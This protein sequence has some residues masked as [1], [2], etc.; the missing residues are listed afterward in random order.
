MTSI[1]SII[2]QLPNL[3]SLNLSDCPNVRTLSPLASVL[4]S[5]DDA[6]ITSAA[7]FSN[8]ENNHRNNE[9]RRRTLALKHL[10]VRGSDLANMSDHEWTNVFE[11]LAESDGPFTRLTLSRNNLTYLHPS[12]G[13][14]TSLTYLFLEDN[15]VDATCTGSSAIYADD[16]SCNKIANN[17]SGF[18]IPEEVGQLQ[19]LR[20]A[21]FCGNNI[22]RLPQQMA[23]LNI[24]CD[25]YLHRNPNLR[26]PPPPYQKNIKLMREFFHNERMALLRGTVLLMPHVT[27]ARSRALERLY[28]PGG[29]GYF[30]AKANFEEIARGINNFN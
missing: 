3:S 12:I 21:S 20:F 13:K 7:T 25:V 28:Q 16:T 23:H 2:A 14:L 5:E 26:Y 27:R 17:N 29:L 19:S 9:S 10:W 15:V 30:E 18:I 22:T 11:A 8:N 4:F 24:N 1:D 6:T